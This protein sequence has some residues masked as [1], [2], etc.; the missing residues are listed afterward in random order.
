MDEDLDLRDFSGICRLFPL[1]GV[2]LF[3]HAVQPLHIFEPRYY[4]MTQD[5]L[6]GDQLI[7]IVQVQPDADWSSS[8]EPAIESVA[9]LGRIIHHERLPDGRFNLL[10]QG[11]ARVRI[12]R[13]LEV[14]TLYRQADVEILHEVPPSE[15]LDPSGSANLIDAFRDVAMLAGGLDPEF[16]AMLADGPPLN[17]VTDLIAQA[18][19]LP[20]AL[21]QVLLADRR[22]DR[23]GHAL[24]TILRQV[25]S[26]SS[27]SSGNTRPFPPPFSNN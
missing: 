20:A 22:A 12:V 27:R 9:C 6:D 7:V 14:P 17:V 24:L 2:V 13:E 1:P 10:L 19:G 18:L 26:N 8:D 11:R 23:R 3:P 15:P 25:A 21:K 5:A 4:Q 16:D